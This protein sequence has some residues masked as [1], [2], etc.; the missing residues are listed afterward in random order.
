MTRT[1][2]DTLNRRVVE[3]FRKHAGQ[4]GLNPKGVQAQYILNWGGFV[5][6]SFRLSDGDKQYHLKLADEAD[7][8]ESLARW[9]IFSQVLAARYHAPRMLDWV[10]IPH[11]DFEGALFEFIPGQPANLAA[12]PVV[13]D[14]VL[15]LLS[16]LHAD[17]ELASA[18][19]RMD[20]GIPTCTDYFLSV[21]IERFDGDLAGIV[22]DLPPFVPLKL[23]DWMMGETRELE[24]LARD[25]PAFQQ[26][27][28]SPTHGDLWP[29]NILV[30]EGDEFSIIDWDDL[31]LGDPALDYSIVLGPL[32]RQGRITQAEIERRLPNDPDL[33]ERFN[34]CLRALIL[35]EV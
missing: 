13:L 34:L 31:S 14:A 28:G 18:L 8:L 20:G 9:R 1:A 12:Q 2:L 5:N 4:Y 22:S 6:A 21:Y 30:V 19:A 11:T 24:G 17:P 15:E 32:W 27:A 25:L 10:R 33:R 35:D 7:S 23:L 16:R 3:Y 29:S 26:P